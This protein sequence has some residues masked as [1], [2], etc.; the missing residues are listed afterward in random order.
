MQGVFLDYWWLAPLA[1][2]AFVAYR[3][4][5]WRGLL[6]VVT[7][8]LVGGVY[9]KGKQDEREHHEREQREREEKA[10]ATRA[11]VDSEVARLDPADKRK[12]LDGWMRDD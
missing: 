4:L 10:R 1:G 2:A 11:E 3:F 6:A 8:G 9:T 5:G 12:R 7:L